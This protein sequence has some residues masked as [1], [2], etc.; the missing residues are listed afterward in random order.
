MCPSPALDVRKRTGNYRSAGVYET[1]S[2]TDEDRDLL[3]Q[4]PEIHWLL[5]AE[6]HLN[7]RRFGA[8]LDRISLLPV[9]TG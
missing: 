1:G 2:S 8:M 6:G 3:C 7:R 5:L 4:D 9:P